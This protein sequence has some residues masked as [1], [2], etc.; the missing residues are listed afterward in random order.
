MMLH[1]QQSIEVLVSTAEAWTQ[2]LLLQQASFYGISSIERH[3][4]KMSTL[5]EVRDR[6]RGHKIQYKIPTLCHE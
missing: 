5:V 6:K 3:Q 1:L 4:W 2:D